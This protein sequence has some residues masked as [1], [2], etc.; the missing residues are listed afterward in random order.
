M[1]EFLPTY[2][3][4]P[5]NCP[6]GTVTYQIVA[7]PISLPFPSFITEFPTSDISIGTSDPAFEGVYNFRI[8]AT[9]TLNGL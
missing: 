5:N 2:E 1:S 3:P 8:I 7:N 9:D 4:N 6:I